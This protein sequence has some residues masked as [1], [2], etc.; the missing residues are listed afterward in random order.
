MSDMFFVSPLEVV[1]RLLFPIGWSHCD[2]YCCEPDG[3]S[4]V[5]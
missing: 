5:G 2:K 4:P 1:K 3:V